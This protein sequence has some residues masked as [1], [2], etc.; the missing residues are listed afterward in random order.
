MKTLCS[1][2]GG[3]IRMNGVHD[4]SMFLFNPRRVSKNR[5]TDRPKRE[6][7]SVKKTRA[8]GFR[9]GDSLVGEAI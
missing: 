8:F 5:K 6:E 4:G 9:G 1:V 2:I 7:L 3:R